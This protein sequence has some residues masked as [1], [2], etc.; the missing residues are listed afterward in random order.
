MLKRLFDW[1]KRLFY[2]KKPF[3]YKYVE[4]VPNVL[5]SKTIYIIGVE[6]NPWQLIMECPCGCKN[7]LHMNLMKEESPVW[8]YV[9]ENKKMITIHPSINRIVGCK[10]HFFIRNGKL[11]WA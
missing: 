7:T 9:I 11:V 6:N 10:S 2:K 4:D 5:K 1:I 3:R 8:S